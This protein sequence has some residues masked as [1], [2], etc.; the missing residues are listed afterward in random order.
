MAIPGAPRVGERE[1]GGGFVP[2]NGGYGE[3]R[4]AP[5]TTFGRDLPF[6][7]V[8]QRSQGLSGGFGSQYGQA[9]QQQ[10]GVFDQFGQMAAGQGPSLAQGQL[11]QGMA[12]AGQQATQAAL[13]ARGGNAAGAQAATAAVNT[14]L[15]GQAA[16]NAAQLRQQEQ[17]AAMGMQAN[18][19]NQMAGQGLQGQ[20]GMESLFQQGL[21]AQADL[22]MQGRQLR[23]QQRNDKVERAKGIKG[24]ILPDLS[25][26]I[27]K[28]NIQPTAGGAGGAG[29]AQG[30]GG[31]QKASGILSLLGGEAAGLGALLALSDERAKQAITPGNLTASQAVGEVPAYAFE[32]KPGMGPDGRH[33]GVMADDMQ[34]VYPAAVQNIGGLKHIDWAKAGALNFAATSEQE[35]RLRQIEQQMG[36]RQHG[37]FG[38]Q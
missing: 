26:P 2:L 3:N 21:G 24:M 35:Q 22:N 6:N 30:Q 9:L 20:L 17:L 10:Q 13:G 1:Y 34:K 32:Y 23:D 4:A 14:S 18:L 15:G 19:A 11:Q 31:L 16:M 33:L 37:A 12:A 28:T 36:M 5:Y 25:D 27:A 29:G 8:L 7:P 38:G